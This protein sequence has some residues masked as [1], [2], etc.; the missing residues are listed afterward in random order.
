MLASLLAPL[1]ALGWESIERNAMPGKVQHPDA[2]R[3]S[4]SRPTTWAFGSVLLPRFC[5]AGF[6]WAMA[7]FAAVAPNANAQSTQ[8]SERV[9]FWDFGS[10]ERTAGVIRS[11]VVRDQPGPR[12][13]EFPDL[14]DHNVCW[15]FLGNGGRFEVADPGASS[16]FDFT[17][18]DVITIEAWVN[19][20]ALS[21]G[22]HAYIIG[23]G[24]THTGDFHRDNQ[25]WAL[26]LTG[27]S[28]GARL[29]F[30]FATTPGANDQH[31][32]RWTSDAS[33][34]IR[35]GWHHVAITYT[36]G[37]PDSIQGW[38]DSQSTAGQWDMGGPTTQA[39]VVDDSPIWIGSTMGGNAAN[40]FRGRM[41]EV[42][43]YRGRV[44]DSQL[45]AR[46]RRVGPPQVELPQ[47]VV[48]S[49]IVE[50][51]FVRFEL[52]DGLAMH[53]QW[54]EVDEVLPEPIERWNGPLL[55]LPRLPFRYDSWGIREHWNP[56]VL[57]RASV[58]LDLPAGAHRFLIRGRGLS[59]LWIDDQVIV[60]LGA[61]RGSSDGHEPV[62]PLPLPPA[63]GHR[64]A[65]YGDVEALGELILLE[66]KR[67][68]VVFESM[69]GSKRL[70]AEPGEMLVA[71]QRDGSDR[72]ELLQAWDRSSPPL[73]LLDN[74]M[75]QAL[76]LARDSIQSYED[77]V[78]RERSASRQ[79]YWNAR[80]RAGADWVQAR[81]PIVVPG[82][83]GLDPQAEHPID[84][85]LLARAEQASAEAE[86]Q[87]SDEATY[88]QQ[89]IAPLLETHCARCH[90][91]KS[92]GGLRLDSLASAE[93]GGDSGEPAVV[94]F[95]AH[96][97]ELV[98][99][100]R[101]TDSSDVMPPE[102]SLEVHQIEAI[103]RWINAGAIWPQAPIDPSTLRP[104]ELSGDTEF[105]RRVA[106]DT[107]GLGP[108]ADEVREFL[109]DSAS[110]KRERWI[111]RWLADDRFADHWVSYWQDVLAE[112]PN[113]LKP[114]LNNSGPFRWFLHDA[115]RDRK[116]VDQWVSE[117]VMMRGSAP[118]GG[119]A[120]FG[121]A[122]DNDAPLAEKAHVL[123]SAFLGLDMKCAR[124]HDSPFHSTTQEQLFSLA[125]MLARKELVVPASSSVA[126]G[127]F[128]AKGRESLIQVTLPVGQ[129]VAPRWQLSE[130]VGIGDSAELDSL[131]ETPA[132]TRERLALLITSPEN[133]RFAQ[134]VVNRVWKR[135]MGA[136][137]V[138]PVDDWEG[139]QAS[140][141][142][143]LRW[144]AYRF[145]ESGYD[146]RLLC[147]TIMTSRA[148][149]RRAVGRNLEATASRR[150][151][152]A[153]DRR[154][155]TAEQ[156]VDSL[157]AS[158]GHV[159]RVEELSFDPDG[160]RA[161][162][163]M[164]S[165]GIPVRAWEFATLSNERD[166]PSL[167]LP[168]AQAVADVLEA[169]GWTA[170][171]TAPIQTRDTQPNVLQSGI[172]ANGVMASWISKASVDSELAE[173]AVHATSPEALVSELSVRFLGRFPTV[174]EARPLVEALAAGF[175]DR[176]VPQSEQVPVTMLPE[177]GRV[178]WSNHLD[179][180]ANAIQLERER[181]ARA[182]DPADPRLRD[183][184][185]EA[186]EDVVW[187][188]FNSPEFVWVP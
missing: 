55:L 150:F 72:F 60:R 19:P 98:R 95:D 2:Y 63:V 42:A 112:N 137:L 132:D 40:S 183:A 134:V 158:S 127:F 120:G 12:P 107:I 7:W 33:F 109:A 142:E 187:A 181:R 177:L 76:E 8:E 169:F 34:P 25:N 35:S 74:Q 50:R 165:L 82:V 147:R 90:V 73:S 117:L 186:Y 114:S 188:I 45:A 179:P 145:V 131:L 151:F 1:E 111:D 153:P 148:Y 70:R 122:A 166:R 49:V 121:V 96:A 23:K 110:D 103:E 144:L 126:P 164:T 155:L 168:R 79:A 159:M 53:D 20:M 54:P 163:A 141:D 58:E 46:F 172:L 104:A 41:D 113:M 11:D 93:R 124:C 43:V 27:S 31:W 157:F 32:H 84:R 100:L 133:E 81:S 62:E 87:R 61:H 135:L 5:L 36:F 47:E 64:I 83:S 66:P 3:L 44:S 51:E 167:S 24:R 154:R 18:G 182:G 17:N 171:R 180:Q 89:T 69:V 30:L 15:K 57:M 152:M 78:R 160:R 91:A 139:A 170:V 115:L 161:P 97:G 39:P 68:V 128:E 174:E 123:G 162:D 92:Q 37:D 108:T 125:A 185:R 175:E 138:E 99:R 16:P 101:S 94:P 71:L 102:G 14:H 156:V 4:L 140:H 65:A 149:Q 119:S 22:S 77:H 13:P 184:W 105:L 178:S 59:R 136:G 176:L 86:E 146:L 88:F 28:E 130:L 29:G 75:P 26:R 52:F 56:P 85:F 80:H 173:L 10:E 21:D 143:L 67:C 9:G 48:P 129:G 116:G 118:A 6:C 106:L 38:I